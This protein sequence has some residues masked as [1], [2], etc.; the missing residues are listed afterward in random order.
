MK[1]LLMILILIFTFPVKVICYETNV[2]RKMTGY[3][4]SSSNISS[5]LKNDLNINLTDNFR[6]RTAQE[7]MEDGSE[8]EDDNWTQRWLNH[9][10][11]PITGSG[12]TGSKAWGQPS[13]QWGKEY[14]SNLWS[15]KWARNYFYN[16][17]AHASPDQRD[18]YFAK[19]FRS[20][21]HIAHLVQDLASPAHVR[22][23]PHGAP[24]INYS[25]YED[26]TK[27]RAASLSYSGYPAVDISVF[28]SFDKFWA[29]S[30]KGLSEYTNTNFFSDDTIFKNYP[31]PARENTTAKLVE[32]TARDGKLDKVWYIQG[33]TSERLAAYSY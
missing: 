5:Y 22:N 3:A 19:L 31:H 17:L 6:D 15:W 32:Q 29:S 27:K 2:H 10:Y 28:N 20:L 30:G 21:G 4:V 26:Y 1:K 12:L 11:D 8:W 24:I 7:W 13:L 33:Y 14:Y 18:A 16:A 25:M 9:F 23:D